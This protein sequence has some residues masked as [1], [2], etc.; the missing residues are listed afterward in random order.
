MATT[1]TT[2]TT[3][4]RKARTARAR[5]VAGLLL[6]LAF[7]SPAGAAAKR[8]DAAFQA[9]VAAYRAGQYPKALKS[10]QSAERAG[11]SSQN[12]DLNLGLTYYQLGR[13]DEARPYFERVRNDLRYTQIADYHLGVMAGK[14]GER[15]EAM[16]YLG[17][18]QSLSTSR[19]LR[20]MASFEMRRLEDTSLDDE[21]LTPDV[22][23]P[24][25]T[26]Y[27]RLSA[28]YDSNPELTSDAV[29]RPVSEA[30]AGY[31]DLRANLE[32]PLVGGPYGTTLFRADLSLRQHNSEDGYDHQSGELGLRQSWRAGRWRFGVGADGGASWL[33]GNA[34]QGVGAVNGD[35]RRRFGET[36]M[37]LRAEVQSIAGEGD[38]AY[39]DGWRQR[40][41][42]Q[43]A[44]TLDRYRARADLELELNDRED[45]RVGEEFNSYSPRRTGLG[46]AVATPPLREV[47]LEFRARWRRSDYRGVDRNEIDGTIVEAQRQDRLVSTGVR[48]RMRGGATWNWLGDYQ[49]NNNDSTIPSDAYARH[50]ATIGVEFLR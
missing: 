34:Y 35:A 3:M 49:Y 50:V 31:A 14:K 5:V 24:D 40:A 15:D 32:H 33:D 23:V 8:G 48:G 7:A 46:L 21:V 10:F 36:Q 37:T 39:L 18:V 17:S 11:M 2:M 4:A 16:Y 44:R 9:G 12:L 6:A 30:G 1:T 42:L 43:V 28:G 29:N 38:Y 27:A 25:G 13:Y 45:R 26:Y 19:D 41:E 20:D 47:A 22:D